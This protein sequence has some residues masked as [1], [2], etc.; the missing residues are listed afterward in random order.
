MSK[1]GPSAKVFA[2]ALFFVGVVF[3][4]APNFLLSIF[5][6]PQTSEV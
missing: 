2:V 5:R 4:A 6:I 3:V 1:S